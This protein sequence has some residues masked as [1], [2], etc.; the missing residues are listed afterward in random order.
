M[1]GRRQETRPMRLKPST[2]YTEQQIEKA[3]RHALASKESGA[4][5]LAIL[6]SVGLL[7]SYV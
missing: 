3:A 5:M 6:F 2:V 4:I 1:L 7:I